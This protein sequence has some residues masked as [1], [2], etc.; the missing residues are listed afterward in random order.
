MVCADRFACTNLF[1]VRTN[2][3]TNSFSTKPTATQ[4]AKEE[5]A[6]R[7][8]PWLL[9][10]PCGVIDSTPAA[11]ELPPHEGGRT[12]TNSFSAVFAL[13][14]NTSKYLASPFFGEVASPV[15][16]T[17]KGGWEEKVFV[18]PLSLLLHR[19]RLS[20]RESQDSICANNTEKGLCKQ[21]CLHEPFI[22]SP[23]SKVFE[24]GYG[25]GLFEKGPSPSHLSVAP[26]SKTL[27]HRR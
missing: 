18:N 26:L 20:P 11:C 14:P 25:E 23:H 21:T 15:A 2:P 19:I 6:G 13:S 10:S 4:L 7:K 16:V 17:E 12:H 3:K 22:L 27:S 1:C 9:D 5:G 24:E 8:L